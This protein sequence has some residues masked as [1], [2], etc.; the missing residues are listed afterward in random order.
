LALDRELTEIYEEHG[1][2]LFRYGTSLARDA[3]DARD[4]VQEV[5]L[6]YYIERCYGREIHNPRAWLYQSLRNHLLNRLK[7]PS[8]REV[9]MEG[10]ES[11][12]GPG[13]TPETIAVQKQLV[14]GVCVGLTERERECLQC[15]TDGLS[16]AE[17]GASLEICSGTVGALLAR[18]YKKI[19]QPAEVAA[20]AA[21]A[22]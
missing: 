16:Y 1:T 4:A 6:R 22:R 5:F 10:L 9:S 12:P 18:A 3:E 17:I 15:R 7:A 14:D 20:G 8:S 2:A 19:R 13:Q 11:I 21:S